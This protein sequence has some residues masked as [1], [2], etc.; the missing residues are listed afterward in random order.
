MQGPNQGVRPSQA[1]PPR[2]VWCEEHRRPVGPDGRCSLCVKGEDPA[3]SERRVVLVMVAIAM[4]GGIGPAAYYFFWARHEED[5]KA[6]AKAAPSTAR[7]GQGRPGPMAE[8]ERWVDEETP[9]MDVAEDPKDK[10]RRERRERPEA[11][12]R[13]RSQRRRGRRGGGRAVWAG[14]AAVPSAVPRATGRVPIT[15]Y[16]A[17]W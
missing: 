10:A 9:P 8:Q 5:R 7:A 14:P 4:L 1:P 13:K 15:L 6:G 12:A 11:R 3:R 16:M 17:H 2:E